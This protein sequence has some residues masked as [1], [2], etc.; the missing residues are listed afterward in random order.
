MA[1][2]M[3]GPVFLLCFTDSVHGSTDLVILESSKAQQGLPA[4]S[5]TAVLSPARWC[6]C[7]EALSSAAEQKKVSPE[8]ISLQV[9]R[10]SRRPDSSTCR[11]VC[12]K[13]Q[14]V[15]N[16]VPQ[17]KALHAEIYQEVLNMDSKGILPCSFCSNKSCAIITSMLVNCLVVLVFVHGLRF[18]QAP[19]W[20]SVL[21]GASAGT[22]MQ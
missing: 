19:V 16:K 21:I 22:V 13:Q 10:A 1:G 4:K 14:K 2:K 18:V 3:M 5:L 11:K 17:I 20:S 15:N 6:C 12:V 9:L 8:L 7:S